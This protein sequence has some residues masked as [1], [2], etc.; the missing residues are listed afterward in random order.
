[1]NSNAGR[2]QPETSPTARRRRWTRRRSTPSRRSTDLGPRSKHLHPW[3]V[4]PF[5]ARWSATFGH[6][7]A[8]ADLPP[9]A[10]VRDGG[11]RG[12]GKACRSTEAYGRLP[13]ARTGLRAREGR[14][15]GRETRLRFVG[16]GSTE[17]CLPTHTRAREAGEEGKAARGAYGRG[18]VRFHPRWV[19]NRG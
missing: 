10:R 1:P 3:P 19:M 8:Y 5:A 4:T 6:A 14:P 7:G 12:G 13:R 15:A 18:G 2:T 17:A 9:H 11:R 16:Y